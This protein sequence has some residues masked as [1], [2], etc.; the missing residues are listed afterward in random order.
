MKSRLLHLFVALTL[1]LSLFSV[2]LPATATTP[3]IRTVDTR[4]WPSNPSQNVPVVTAPGT[5]DGSSSTSDGSGGIIMVWHDN[6]SGNNDIYAQQLN[7]AGFPQWAAD[8][9]PI[10]MADG[11]QISPRITSDGAGGAFISWQDYRNG[12]DYNI[13][14][15]RINSS[16]VTQWSPNGIA[17]NAAANN[18]DSIR[19]LGDGSGGAIFVWRDWRDHPNA[20][21]YAQR[22]DSSGTLQW[23]ADGMPVCVDSVNQSSPQ[24]RG[25]GAGG[26]FIVW[27]DDRN[28]SGDIYAQRINST[29]APEWV[30]NGVP[31]CTAGG[32]QSNPGQTGDGADGVIVTWEDESNSA[33]TGR[34][35]FAQRVDSTGTALWKPNG[36]AVSNT[37]GDQTSVRTTGSG[38]NLIVA[39]TDNRS[40][41][42]DIYAQSVNATGGTLWTDNGTA[43]STATGDQQSPSMT[44]G[45][46]GSVII[47][48]EDYRSGTADIYAQKI[49]SGSAA[50]ATNGVA[51]STAAGG[52]Y[53][54]RASYDNAGGAIFF[55]ADERNSGTTGRD[56]YAQ[57]VF[58]DGSLTSQ[59]IPV[60]TATNTQ[61]QAF[62]IP[63]GN[64]GIFITWHD[65]RSGTA[66]IYAQHIS[67]AGT[68]QWPAGGIPICT[69]MNIQTNPRIVTD[70][71]GGA[72]IAWQDNR[73]GAWDVYAQRINS[74]G[75]IQWV[76]DGVPANTATNNQESV[77]LLTDNASGAIL[78][79]RDYRTGTNY[80][81]YA[82]KINSSG[83][84]QW[85]ADGVAVCINDVNQ[86]SVQAVP[87]G[88]GGVL[89]T[90][91]DDRSTNNDIYVQGID[92]AG[93]VRW[94]T[95]GV[96][97]C[98]DGSNQVN[99][100]TTHDDSGG[101]IIAW[102]D[103]RNGNFDIY[104]QSVNATG[105][106]QW[107]A[108]GVVVT[109]A[110]LDQTRIRMR[111]Q[112]SGGAVLAWTDNRSGNLDI[113]A[114]SV[115]S[116]GDM[117]WAANGIPI[118]T[119][120]GNQD[121]L[122]IVG[123]GFGSGTI[124]AWEDYRGGSYSDIYAQKIDYDGVVQWATVLSISEMG[125]F[126]NR[127]L[128]HNQAALT[129]SLRPWL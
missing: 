88:S 61:D 103:Y 99:S 11:N 72:I 121:N 48:W 100:S 68:P 4:A 71:A 27:S 107:A 110:S 52:Q 21:I 9:V 19:M 80:D 56:I 126:L 94:T 111:G 45:G 18:Q 1:V 36:V 125:H 66:D 15:Q 74:S 67:A 104:A 98:T 77:R 2:A 10:C 89:I 119:A 5:Q 3:E 59:N 22:I 106:P 42:W 60:V 116:T 112:P 108:N 55:W 30:T 20:D 78:V 128:W 87:D 29:G 46:S 97:V 24:A 120:G 92:S 127:T 41:E 117:G 115:N 62:S 33:V 75:E 28:G 26:A 35:V 84:V 58:P 12:T 16:G 114:Q 76:A 81:I 31:V 54:P 37:G 39:W 96:A 13:Y 51:V 65:Y 95:N 86:N 93:T 53:S 123:G 113:Y 44:S 25:D 43:I 69:D 17:I 85:V 105:S 47:T 50:W 90:W 109:D 6:R 14:A 124:I 64:G 57:K 129:S 118:T 34:D 70:G 63:D 82:Q 32:N 91:Y 8:G 38:G 101:A 122:S 102:E 7:A 40:G 83:V 73:D 49:I 79:W 23:A